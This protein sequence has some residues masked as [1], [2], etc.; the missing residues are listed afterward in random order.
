M[1]ALDQFNLLDGLSKAKLRVS[2]PKPNIGTRVRSISKEGQ[3][4][5]AG[6]MGTAVSM[7]TAVPPPAPSR[8]PVPMGIPMGVPTPGGAANT[9]DP[10]S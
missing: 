10:I 1:I 6:A 4:L 5:L 9:G 2:A 7:D 8:V 3:A